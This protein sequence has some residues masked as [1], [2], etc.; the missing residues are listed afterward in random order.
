MTPGFRIYR[1]NHL[2]KRKAW[3]PHAGLGLHEVSSGIFND[4][5]TTVNLNGRSRDNH[6]HTLC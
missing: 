2:Q 5:L 1:V 4:K 6:A 3:G